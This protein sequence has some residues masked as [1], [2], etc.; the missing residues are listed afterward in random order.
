MRL[1][2]SAAHSTSRTRWFDSAAARRTSLNASSGFPLRQI[3]AQITH[4]FGP[5][6]SRTRATSARKPGD[7]DGGSLVPR[8]TT[9]Y[10]ER[11]GRPASSSRDPLVGG[12]A[13]AVVRDD[14]PVRQG[15]RQ[16]A[17][18]AD[19]EGV[20]DERRRASRR[21]RRG[22]RAA[23][24]LDE[25]SGQGRDEEKRREEEGG[26]HRGGRS[27]RGANPAG[28]HI[29]RQSTASSTRRASPSLPGA[30][31]PRTWPISAAGSSAPVGSSRT[32]TC[33]R[34]RSTPPSS[35]AGAEGSHRRRSLGGS[36]PCGRSSASRSAPPACPRSPCHRSG[37]GAYRTRRSSP[38]SRRSSPR[39]RAT[40]RWR[41]ATPRCSS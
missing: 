6:S 20:A 10:E 16:V 9:T 17:L 27:G 36:P 19:V 2:P 11:A 18:D 5:I 40:A 13:D 29:D 7:I 14:L 30:P 15:I 34:S 26:A 23:M 1:E 33:R 35:A 32:S 28:W 4:R 41:C 12:A 39:S 37:G 38:R 22:R 31:T 8:L 24:A 21:G 25:Q 3:V